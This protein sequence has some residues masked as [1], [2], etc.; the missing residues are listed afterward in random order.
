M[1]IKERVA[2]WGLILTTGVGYGI[3]WGVNQEKVKTL[4]S[5]IATVSKNE[6]S[7]S[8]ISV[9]QA[10]IDERTKAILERMNKQDDMMKQILEEVSQ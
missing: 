4:E 9:E 8:K 5:T 2:L 1:N 10:R 7:I 3:A 6:D